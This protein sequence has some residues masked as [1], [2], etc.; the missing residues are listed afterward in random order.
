MRLRELGEGR[1][2]QR[3]RDRFASSGAV[4]GIGDD[5]A[6]VD[7]PAYPVKVEGEEILVGLPPAD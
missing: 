7:I 1:L 4:L 2:I 3:I 6:I 5:A